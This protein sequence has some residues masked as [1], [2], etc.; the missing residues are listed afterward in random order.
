MSAKKGPKPQGNC[1]WHSDRKA[2]SFWMCESC[3][4]KVLKPRR[5]VTRNR[6]QHLKFEYGI[7]I[8]EFTKLAEAQNYQCKICGDKP[9]VLCVDHSH[10]TGHIRALLCRACNSALGRFKDSPLILQKAIGY[11]NASPV[12]CR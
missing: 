11:L 9:D 3:Y 5:S 12:T 7:G 8:K 6:E 4:A 2:H 1:F 10:E